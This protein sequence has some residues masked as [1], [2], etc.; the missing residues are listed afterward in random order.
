LLFFHRVIALSFESRCLSRRID[1]EGR[2]RDLSLTQCCT[3]ADI[4]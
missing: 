1:A 3:G 4:N 2:T